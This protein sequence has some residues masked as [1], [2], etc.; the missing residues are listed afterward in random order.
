MFV[1]LSLPRSVNEVSNET[2]A[3]GINLFYNYRSLHNRH[4]KGKIPM[5]VQMILCPQ[6]VSK[7]EETVR[8]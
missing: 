6:L 7:K 4:C 3:N 2:E 8:N 5:V 1:G